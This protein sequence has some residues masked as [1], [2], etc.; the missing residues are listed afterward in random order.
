MTLEG[1]LVRLCDTISYVGRDLEDAIE[2]GL[3][4]RAELPP[5]VAEV[6][7]STNGTIVYRLVED[8]LASPREGPLGFSPAVAE[9][10]TRLKNF[11]RARIYS[12]PRAKTE[13]PKIRR[14]Y[15]ILFEAFLE[16]FQSGPK[17]PAA[18]RFI[19]GLEEGYRDAASPAEKARDL[20]AGMTDEYFLR[21]AAE[22]LMPEWHLDC[23]A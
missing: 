16:D 18:K 6:L 19:E 9:A 3:V 20:V 14:L 17:L 11:N 7:G 5:E 1:C 22:L 13:A 21:Q 23:F 8:L 10:L 12:N 2:V 4:E 15:R